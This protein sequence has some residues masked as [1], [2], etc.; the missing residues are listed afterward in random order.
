MTRV[1]RLGLLAAFRTIKRLKGGDPELLRERAAEEAI[2]AN[3]PLRSAELSRLGLPELKGM[4]GRAIGR[5]CGKL[6]KRG[7][8]EQVS[9]GVWA[10]TAD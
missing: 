1:L 3:L 10:T 2:L 9:G 5:I 7:L 6:R 8:V 4:D